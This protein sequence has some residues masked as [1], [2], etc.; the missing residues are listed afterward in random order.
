M[1][2][3]EKA[4]KIANEEEAKKLLTSFSALFQEHEKRKKKIQKLRN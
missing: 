3:D 2:K 1:P 4:V